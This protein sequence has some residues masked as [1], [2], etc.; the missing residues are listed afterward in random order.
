MSTT[1]SGWDG[2]LDDGETIL[3][4]GRPDSVIVW[5][6]LLSFESLFGV[7]FAGFAL[8]WITAATFMTAGQPSFQ[9]SGGIDTVFKVFPLFG[10]PFLAV[11]L[12][13]VVGRIFWDAYQRGRT[14]YTLTDRAAYIARDVLGRRTLKRYGTDDMDAP[15]LQDDTPGSVMFAEEISTYHTSSR[16]SFSQGRRSRTRTQRKAIGF[17]RIPD[18]RAVYR[19]IV[20]LRAAHRE[21]QA[22]PPT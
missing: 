21:T 12:Y 20:D 9:G 18:A 15:A 4:Q 19:L 2:I 5:K 13:M 17:H 6:D 16:S 7:F 1:Q 10:L 22:S 14:W 11:G 8:F 3:W